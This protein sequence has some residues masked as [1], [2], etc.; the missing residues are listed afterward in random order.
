MPHDVILP[1]LGTTMD[2]GTLLR[3]MK[4]EGESVRKGEPLF[5]VQTDKVNL[6]VES[7]ADGVLAR[8]L[9]EPGRTAKVAE[10][11]ALIAA[12]GEIVSDSPTRASPPAAV[13][14]AATSTAATAPTPGA[15]P[16]A[17]PAEGRQFSSPAARR[18]A[19]ELGVDL[20]TAG[21]RGSGPGG[22]IV[23][24]DVQRVADAG[25]RRGADTEAIAA[26]RP[27][28]H[29]TNL[30]PLTPARR[31]TAQRMAE[32]ARTIPHFYLTVDVRAQALATLREKLNAGAASG[33][34]VSYSDLI[35]KAAAR[36]LRD[37]PL[38]NAA[39]ADGQIRMNMDIH[40]GLAMA[41]KDGLRVPV[42]HR[43]DTLSVSDVARRRAD[44]ETRLTD[45]RLALSDLEGATFTISNLGM[46]GIDAFQ[47]IINPPQAAILAV[48]RIADRVVAENGQAVVRPMMTLTLGADHRVCDGA[49][50]ARFLQA[51]RGALESPDSLAE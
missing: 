33:V 32:S 6:E 40:I 48:G 18:L 10:V 49:D 31:V 37:H 27:L 5:E 28:L 15:L 8:I 38:L 45:G 26:G 35:V 2:E 4:K 39:W 23:E 25:G 14:A 29:N 43:A 44:L 42:I 1:K 16:A 9:C 11:I 13:H 36:T 21:I 22:R 20:P 34:R 7:P 12:P 30:V 51:L 47:A 46:F 3:W 17:G 19:R 24:R 41:A 50:A